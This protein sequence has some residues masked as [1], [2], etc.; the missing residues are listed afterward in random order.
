MTPRSDRGRYALTILRV[1]VGFVFIMHGGQKL[2]VFGLG[3]VTEAFAAS[4]IPLAT[5]A[6]PAVTLIEFLGGVALVL[7]L[8]TSVVSLLLGIVMFGALVMVHLQGGFFLPD[9]IEFTLTLLAASISLA[10]AGPGAF[11][12]DN[13]R[14]DR[15]SAR[16]A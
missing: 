11:A 8:L 10:L 5:L 6:G 3:G 16:L 1:I 15:S 2:L 7:G 14:N 13:V 9:G 12:L 4:G